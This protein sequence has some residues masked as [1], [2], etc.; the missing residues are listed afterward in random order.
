MFA[1][2][3]LGGTTY[4]LMQSLIVPAIPDI[5]HS[6]GVSENAASW[7]LTA[8]LL[9]ASV[10][11]PILGRLGDMYGKE[12]LL[13]IVLALLCVGTVIGA[14][15]GSL[16]LLLVGRVIQGAAGGIFPLA[17]GIIRD[18]FP[19]ER[20]AGGIGLMS[21]LLGVGA[22]LGFV[23]AGPIAD[24]LS[25][26]YLFWLPLVPTALATVLTYLFVP[27]SPVRVPGQV[28]WL[29]ALLMSA[30]LVLVLI[31]VSQTSTWHWLSAK[32]LG[33]IAA[34]LAV[35]V[36]W[37]SVESRSR[38]PLVDM[39]MMRLRGVWTTNLVALLLGFGMYATFFLIPQ[40]VQTDGDGYGFNASVTGAGLFMLPSTVAML[41]V[42]AQTGRLEK[43]FGSKPPLLVGC[44]LVL[45]SFLVM[46]FAH[47]QK[48]EVLLAGALLGAGVGLA[49]ASM[50]NL[51]IE[52]VG[53]A[54]TGV[55]T[56]MNTVTRTIGGSFG[57]AATAS[58]IAGT[59]VAGSDIP[60]EHGYTVAFALCAG[61]LVVGLCV[62]FL[63]PQR[64]PEA[65]FA[66][67]AVG[68]L[69]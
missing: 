57:A 31:A 33:C 6:L 3:I 32:T 35:L 7:V 18:E 26:H 63:I 66:A 61:V 13:V 49:F 59:V 8:Y 29:A 30:G 36:L 58:L 9:S 68:D 46:A 10:A 56:G 40:F 14:V 12:R 17:F 23:L 51:I 53:P 1:V 37:V 67:H 39:R 34:G 47:D 48:W 43:R 54:E 24:N 69:D 25:Y 16:A 19:R 62:G 44:V 41:I 11:T 50:A 15:A 52:N 45:M 27:E 4:A 28:N 55:A 65:A 20:V 60:T 42:G 64:R 21:A 5:Q 38:Q 2:L 22:G